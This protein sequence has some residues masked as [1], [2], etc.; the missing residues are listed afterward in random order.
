MGAPISIGNA[1]SEYKMIKADLVPGIPDHLKGYDKL[2]VIMICLNEKAEN[3]SQLTA[4]LNTIPNR[5][6][7]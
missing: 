3:H 2:A 6:Q 5:S 4:M 7:P 1:I